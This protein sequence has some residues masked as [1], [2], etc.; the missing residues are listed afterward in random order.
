METIASQLSYLDKKYISLSIN[1][2]KSDTD[3]T[4]E[5]WLIDVSG[6]MSS[7]I[8]FMNDVCKEHFNK[9]L[10]KPFVILFNDSASLVD[11]ILDLTASG[12]TNF[13]SAF[14]YLK[15][16][17][18]KQKL[19]N[20]LVLFITDGEDSGSTLQLN[21]Y[22]NDVLLQDIIE[23]NISFSTIGYGNAYDFQSIKKITES[24]STNT[25]QLCKSVHDLEEV[26]DKFSSMRGQTFNLI[27]KSESDSCK[28]FTVDPIKD[29]IFFEHDDQT[30]IVNDIKVVPI[31]K[32]LSVDDK[33]NILEYEIKKLLDHENPK[34][35]LSQYDKILDS[36][37][38]EKVDN[39]EKRIKYASRFV[40]IKKLIGTIY[41]LLANDLPQEELLAGKYSIRTGVS[42]FDKKINK[43]ILSNQNSTIYKNI[44]DEFSKLDLDDLYGQAD[45]D[46]RCVISGMDYLEAI[47]T[48]DCLGITF[49]VQRTGTSIMNYEMLRIVKVN[50]DFMT[51]KTF[52]SVLKNSLLYVDNIEE[53]EKAIGNIKTKDNEAIQGVL[54]KD[55]IISKC[56]AFLPLY[57]TEDHWKM[58]KH[59][60]SLA[61]GFNLSGDERFIPNE[62]INNVIPFLVLSKAYLDLGTLEIELKVYDEI[63]LTCQTI[64]DPNMISYYPLWIKLLEQLEYNKTRCANLS[65]FIGRSLTLGHIFNENELKA[66]ILENLRRKCKNE[67]EI[68]PKTHVLAYNV[69]NTYETLISKVDT[70]NVNRIFNYGKW[71]TPLTKNLQFTIQ[72][73]TIYALWAIHHS[74][75]DQSIIDTKCPNPLISLEDCGKFI[76]S[77][78]ISKTMKNIEKNEALIK[79][80]N[81][82]TRFCQIIDKNEISVDITP[83]IHLYGWRGLSIMLKILR[84][85]RYSNSKKQIMSLSL[86]KMEYLQKKYNLKLSKRNVGAFKYQD[87]LD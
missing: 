10:K 45:K 23:Y 31:E 68:L 30:L 25:F 15:S 37:Q 86:L 78:F 64:I 87:E 42:R 26:F 18:I 66:L 21:E 50:F 76:V 58:A 39:K 59:Y 75:D 55:R 44:D 28:N 14:N 53:E 48:K 36:I 13:Q 84:S 73:K 49:T 22:V 16:L 63:K 9:R 65:L 61:N 24:R 69:Y 8:R 72:E 85:E 43:T 5:I 19:K 27:V 80:H 79:I 51:Y 40:I 34:E 46:Y 2:G 70:S 7:S 62:G 83:A 6:S 74:Q 57:I 67:K 60:M 32:E 82:M 77:V 47:A 33:Y 11:D 20:P 29:E 81:E 12:G 3:D 4:N 35:L 38:T 17:I 54:I 1:G 71:L 56:N 41:K 52:Q